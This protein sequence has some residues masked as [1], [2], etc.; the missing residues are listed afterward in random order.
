M[1]DAGYAIAMREDE[2]PQTP[3]LESDTDD[4]GGRLPPG[5]AQ[6][7]R[8]PE[9]SRDDTLPETVREEDGDTSS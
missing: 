6:D 5:E 1:R 9:P 4:A 3:Q 7:R 8:G 2:P